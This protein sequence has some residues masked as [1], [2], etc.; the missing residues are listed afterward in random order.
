LVSRASMCTLPKLALSCVLF[1]FL[2][3]VVA[4]AWATGTALGDVALWG[5][6]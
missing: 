6:C 3:E 1:L 5:I 4:H 2:R